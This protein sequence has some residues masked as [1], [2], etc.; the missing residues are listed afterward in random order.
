MFAEGGIAPLI[1]GDGGIKQMFEKEL[2]Y[3]ELGGRNYPYKCTIGVLEKLQDKYG[4]LEDFERELK[5]KN[6]KQENK[7]K[8][9][10]EVG[11]GALSFALAAMIAEGMEIE[12][13]KEN[14]VTEADIRLYAGDEYGLYELYDIVNEEFTR[15]FKMKKNVSATQG[16]EK[17]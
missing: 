8:R 17:S 7:V 16:K 2:K 3:I 6:Q 14:P 13:S 12:Q 15:C 1:N 11:I 10:L 9:R 5:F 4:T